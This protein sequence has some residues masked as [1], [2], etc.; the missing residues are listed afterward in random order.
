MKVTYCGVQQ[1]CSPEWTWSQSGPAGG[2]N[3]LST[4]WSWSPGE[5]SSDPEQRESLLQASQAEVHL[6]LPQLPFLPFLVPAFEREL[7]LPVG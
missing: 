4:S 3:S 1:C 5:L 6:S 7:I 2:Q